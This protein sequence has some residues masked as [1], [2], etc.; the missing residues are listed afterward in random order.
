MATE[1]M[2]HIDHTRPFIEI[3]QEEAQYIHPYPEKLVA[4]FKEIDR[5][6]FVPEDLRDFLPRVYTD[7]GRAGLLSQPGVIFAMVARLY[8]KGHETVFE[9]GHRHRVSDRNPCKDVQARLQR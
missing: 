9:G 1:K 8:L 2:S 5:A 3:I 6:H 7:E 4:L